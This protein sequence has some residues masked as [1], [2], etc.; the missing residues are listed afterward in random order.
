[1]PVNAMGGN[2]AA[3]AS[4]QLCRGNRPALC[5]ATVAL[6]LILVAYSGSPSVGGR[7]E[8]GIVAGGGRGAVGA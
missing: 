3:P 5:V 1:M 8:D 6:G 7:D 4:A 2:R